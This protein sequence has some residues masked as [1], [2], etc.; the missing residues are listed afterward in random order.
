[1]RAVVY[2][3][4]GPAN[5][6]ELREVPIPVPKQDEVLVRIRACSVNSWDW[7]LLT[8]SPFIARIDSIR[9]PEHPILGCDIAGVVEAVGGAVESLA[10]GDEVMGDTSGCGFGG[11]AEYVAI[12]ADVL[13]RKPSTTTFDEAAAIPQAG[14]LALQG[15]RKAGV[16][17]GTRLLMNGAGGGVG[18]FAIQMAKAIGAEV[19]AVD[20]GG[21]LEMLRSI[22]ADHVLDYREEDFATRGERYDAVLDVAARRSVFAHRRV[23]RPGGRYVIIGGRTWTLASSTVGGAILRFVDGKHVGILVHRPNPDDLDAVNAMVEAGT[24]SPVID[25]RYPLEKTGDA[26]NRIGSGQALG[27]LIITM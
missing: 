3:D 26:L 12:R 21:K 16:T 6:L 27:K 5:G 7:D 24:V 20:D 8:G 1:M 10:V 25:R 19:T 4:Y 23:L 15:L 13:S 18:T 17:Q 11:F 22:G 2:D 14:V 9:S